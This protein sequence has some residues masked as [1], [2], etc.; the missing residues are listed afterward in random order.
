MKKGTVSGI[1]KL[2]GWSFHF[3]L[4]GGVMKMTTGMPRKPTDAEHEAISDATKHLNLVLSILA[5]RV[6]MWEAG[7]WNMRTAHTESEEDKNE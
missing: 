5:E 4:E 2:S 7:A 3:E 1:I 6:D